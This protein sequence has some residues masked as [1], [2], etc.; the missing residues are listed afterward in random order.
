MLETRQVL[1]IDWT[2]VKQMMDATCPTIAVYTNCIYFKVK[3]IPV[4]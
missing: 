3:M 4:T 2:T 1:Q